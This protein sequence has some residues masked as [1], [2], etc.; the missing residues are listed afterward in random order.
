MSSVQRRFGPFNLGIIGLL[1]S[2][3]NGINLIFTQFI[4]PRYSLLFSILILPFLFLIF[5]LILFSFGF[6]L[7]ILDSFYLFLLLFIFSTL[8][9]LIMSFLSSSSFS[10]Y[11][12]IGSLRIINQFISFSLIFDLIIIIFTFSYSFIIFSFISLFLF[13]SFSFYIFFSFSSLPLVVQFL[14]NSDLA[15]FLSCTVFDYVQC[16]CGFLSH[17]F[18]ISPCYM[19]HRLTCVLS[20]SRMLLTYS[21]AQPL[22]FK[23][24]YNVYE[25]R[26]I[27]L[28]RLSLMPNLKLLLTFFIIFIIS[29]HLFQFSIYFIYYLVLLGLGKSIMVMIN[30][31]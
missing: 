27:D 8:L 6:P 23:M 28:F 1:A 24:D 17:D 15:G 31:C 7:F 30:R 22:N 5:L 12:F 11:S 25:A 3:L 16:L 10:K 9:I 2:I 13:S 21:Y 29:S 14:R 26:M 19:S 4:I 18:R 20:L